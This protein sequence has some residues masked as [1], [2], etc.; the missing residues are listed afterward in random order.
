MELEKIINM[1]VEDG[2]S[3][4]AIAEEFG[5]Y[6][7]KIRRA[8]VSSGVELRSKSAAQKKALENGRAKHP[9]KGKKR[10]E[11]EKDKISASLE[12]SWSN[13]TKKERNRRSQMAKDQ[14]EN[15]PEADKLALRKKAA[16]ALLMTVKHGS[17][18]EKLLYEKLT[19][20]GY[21]VELHKKD[22]I[23]GKKYEMDLY[24]PEL[25]T[26]IEVDGPQHFKPLFGEKGLREYV[27]HDIIKNGILL[28]RGYCVIR[29][30]YLCSNYSRAVGRR[31]CELVEPVVNRVNK[32]F[33]TKENRL[34]ELEIT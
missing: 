14:W 19:E 22:M 1:Y 32:K 23:E 18:P 6:P 11:E 13:V 25:S 15:M 9:T 24:L 3:T 12:K 8:L 26:V 7:N 5:T 30:K 2:M 34:I 20:A 31:L 33:P 29:V 17:N 28:K 27:K 21:E 16:E 10:S 4:K